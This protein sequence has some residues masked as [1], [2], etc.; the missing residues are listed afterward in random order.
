[1]AVRTNGTLWAWGLNDDG[2]LGDGTNTTRTAPVQIG[3]DTTWRNV[4]VSD[5]HTLATRTNNTL[6]AWGDNAGGQLGD[7]TTTDRNAP[8]QVGSVAAW[9]SIA[10]G[11]YGA[12]SF[13][14]ATQ[15]DKSVWVWG[16]S[17]LGDGTAG[18]RL[19]PLRLGSDWTAISATGHHTLAVRSDGTLWA[20]GEQQRRTAR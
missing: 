2:E 13:S 20:W 14:V 17:Y 12:A 16:S 15:S 18:P 1:M 4:A 6:W 10:A 9:S 11:G 8:A 19:T 3:S 5:D 7:G